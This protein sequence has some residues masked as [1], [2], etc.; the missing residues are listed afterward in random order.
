MQLNRPKC[1]FNGCF[2]AVI[3]GV[4]CKLHSH[5]H[6]KN[7]T[8]PHTLEVHNA[9]VNA[10]RA[11]VN[12]KAREWYANNRE[13]RKAAARAQYA[14]NKVRIN[15]LKGLIG[16]TDAVRER[17]KIL[18]RKWITQP[19]KRMRQLFL[20]ARSRAK[21]FGLPFDED[22]MQDLTPPTHCRCCGKM[23]DYS[24]AGGVK[25]KDDSP[26]IDKIIPALGYVPKNCAV[27]CWRCNME[28]RDL[29]VDKIELILEY[30]NKST[31]AHAQV[32]TMVG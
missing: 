27:I 12:A 3:T 11:Q 4:F 24:R 23:L 15:K 22:L 7:K 9:Y 19:E 16:K 2:N 28:K 29:T 8:A 20:S 18:M 21:K 32:L 13:K 6:A 14:A 17:D 31:W 1:A 26:S 5:G 10:H 25:H 30:I